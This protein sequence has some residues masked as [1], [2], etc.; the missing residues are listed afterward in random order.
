[1]LS[2]LKLG[3]C[4]KIKVCY[5]FVCIFLHAKTRT[6]NFR[7]VVRQHTRTEGM[8]GSII[9]VLLEI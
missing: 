6:S 9:W 2:A 5:V 8:V 4:S 3:V 1:M 7:E